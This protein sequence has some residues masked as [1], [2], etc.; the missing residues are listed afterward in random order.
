MVSESRVITYRTER[1]KLL[2]PTMAEK[3]LSS[4]VSTKRL[5]SASFPVYAPSPSTPFNRI[6]APRA[7]EQ[8]ERVFPSSPVSGVEGVDSGNS[9]L[10]DRGVVFPGLVARVGEVAQ[11]SEVQMSFPVGQELHFQIL[12]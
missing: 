9:G 10:Q 12:Q 4:P 11:Q 2:S 6:P 1:S 8:I 5:N 7:V 3:P